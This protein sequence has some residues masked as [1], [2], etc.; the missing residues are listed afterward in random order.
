MRSTQRGVGDATAL[1]FDDAS[2]DAVVSTQV[3]E[4]VP[5]V[6]KAQNGNVRYPGVSMAAPQHASVPGTRHFYW[7]ETRHFHFAPTI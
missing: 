4:Y 1:P 6:P 3:Y 2:F 5:D 7:G